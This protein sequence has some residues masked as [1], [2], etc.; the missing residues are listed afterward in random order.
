ML[1]AVRFFDN[2]DRLA[3]RRANLQAHLDW[4]NKNGET[5]LVAGSLRESPGEDAVGGLWIVQAPSKRAVE[6]L[7]GTDPFTL[8]GL[9]HKIEILHWSKAFEDKSVVI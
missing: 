2:A 4:L 8:V 5:V 1:F 3:L 6:D 7:I 9:R